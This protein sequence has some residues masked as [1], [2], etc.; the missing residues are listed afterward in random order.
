MVFYPDQKIAF[1]R[2]GKSG[3]S[4]VVLYLREAIECKQSKTGDDRQ[5]K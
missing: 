5:G 2:I 3:N 4:S 1:N